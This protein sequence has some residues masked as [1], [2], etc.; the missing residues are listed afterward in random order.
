MTTKTQIAKQAQE[1]SRAINA[2]HTAIDA[3]SATR[4][5]WLEAAPVVR[6]WFWYGLEQWREDKAGI[7]SKLIVPALPQE[8]Q[9]A[10]L[11]DLPRKGTKAYDEYV[12]SN[13][14]AQFDTF[15]SA[16]I[17]ARS[18][19]NTMFGRVTEYAF[20]AEIEVEKV[21]K[22]ATPSEAIEA[23]EGD[24]I[25]GEVKVDKTATNKGRL[26]AD[27]SNWVKRLQKSEGEDFDINATITALQ[28]TLAILT[29]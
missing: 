2:L 19:A 27:L 7:I 12:A 9:T 15:M 10:L 4:G 13:G 3:E 26:M 5:K 20:A 28:A 23:S 6:A 18:Y 14:A 29:K 24:D 22:K 11:R 17:V 21:A 25:D 8:Q 1:L 16:K